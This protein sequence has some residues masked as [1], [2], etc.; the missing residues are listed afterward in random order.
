MSRKPLRR[1]LITGASRGLGRAFTEAALD[2]GDTVVATA[3]TP[4]TLHDLVELHGDRVVPMLL[5]VTDRAAVFATVNAAAD[6][7]G[8]LDVLVNNAGYGLSGAVEEIS[9]QQVRAQ[10]D[11][12]FFGALWC[13]QAV[14]PV[15]R[16]QRSGH[17]FQIS[18]IAALTAYPNLGAYCASKWALD[19][20]SDALAQEVAAFGIGVT[21]VELGEFRTDWSAGSMDRATP[22]PEYDEVL[23]KRR[24]G[25]SG[26]YAHLQPGDP[27]KAAEALLAVLDSGEPPRRLLL[28]SGCA[29]FAPKVYRDRIEEWSRWDE[30]ARSVDHPA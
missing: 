7:V 11:V 13:A 29:D 14:L 26:A 12:N 8:G 10:M 25:M 24:I 23:A 6:R 22:M 30:L 20:L 27:R 3:R 17:L 5:D 15:M 21:I 1:W 19:G 2:A 16:G 9:E 28:G 4:E 18:S